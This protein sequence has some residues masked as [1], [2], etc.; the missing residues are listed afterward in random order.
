MRD[1]KFSDW[2]SPFDLR[3]LLGEA[4]SI[5]IEDAGLWMV[6]FRFGGGE[7][8]WWKHVAYALRRHEKEVPEG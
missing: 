4:K 1:G 6:V 2:L 3:F 8:L 5:P 7:G